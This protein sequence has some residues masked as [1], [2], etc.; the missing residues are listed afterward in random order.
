D[1]PGLGVESHNESDGILRIEHTVDHDRGGAQVRVASSALAT[2]AAPAAG[3]G[4]LTAA[5]ALSGVCTRRRT[6]PGNLQ[7]PDIVSVDLIERRIAREG[8]IAAKV[9]PFTRGAS[10]LRLDDGT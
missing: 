6:A 7:I 4:A 2:L 3:L 10:A 1:A 9:A 5:A 8:V